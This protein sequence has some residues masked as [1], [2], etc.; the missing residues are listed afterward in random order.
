MFSLFGKVDIMVMNERFR[1]RCWR[2]GVR[3][4]TILK[5]SF[6][7]WSE[8]SFRSFYPLQ[9]AALQEMKYNISV[10]KRFRMTTETEVTVTVLTERAERMERSVDEEMQA[11]EGRYYFKGW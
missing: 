6:A 7:H 10:E 1:C 4:H 9:T 11:I 8:I 5:R 3:R 2:P